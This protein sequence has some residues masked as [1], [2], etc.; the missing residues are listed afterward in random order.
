MQ[1]SKLFFSLQKANHS[2]HVARR[3]Q[4]PH[5]GFL[6]FTNMFDCSPQC[7][8]TTSAEACAT[9]NASGVQCLRRYIAYSHHLGSSYVYVCSAGVWAGR[10][11]CKVRWCGGGGAAAGGSV[12]AGGHTTTRHDDQA[13]RAWPP[14]ETLLYFIALFMGWMCEGPMAGW[15]TVEPRRPQFGLTPAC[16]SVYYLNGARESRRNSTPLLLQCGVTS[17]VARISQS[18]PMRGGRRTAAAGFAA[19]AAALLFAAAGV[20]AAPRA[21]RQNQ[22]HSA[23]PDVHDIKH[24]DEIVHVVFSSH[25]DV[26][27][28][29]E[30]FAAFTGS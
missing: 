15:G 5:L 28:T 29:G 4:Q 6:T 8:R 14:K 16:C 2:T 3:S 20:A 1:A 23:K 26:G 13:R 10:R 19:L 11:D 25:F 30:C 9:C 27:F 18:A 22:E 7:P 12:A 24:S 17:T 21:L